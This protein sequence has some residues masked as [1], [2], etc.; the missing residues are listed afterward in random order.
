MSY[1]TILVPLCFLFS[2]GCY[3]QSDSLTVTNNLIEDYLEL[4]DK[5]LV[6]KKLDEVFK[7]TELADL[8][9]LKSSNRYSL[10]RIKA[11]DLRGKAYYYKQAYNE[12]SIALEKAI[13]IYDKSQLEVSDYIL[14][15]FNNLG[16]IQQGNGD[17]DK[18]LVN[19]K[20]ALEL[21][22]EM[23][24]DPSPDLAS[25]LSKA[26]SSFQYTQL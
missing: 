10:N 16:T 4:A 23:S 1:T 17:F 22:K 26:A 14:E 12:A 6:D 15:L 24:D 8:E 19:F 5:H 13:D 11:W 20:K 25:R 7:Y 18:G 3:C 9:I 2:I 21:R